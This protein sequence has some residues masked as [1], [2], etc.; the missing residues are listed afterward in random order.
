MAKVWTAPLPA[1]R[2][3]HDSEVIIARAK[4]TSVGRRV[5]DTLPWIDDETE[6]FI[7]Y[8]FATNQI[9]R[10]TQLAVCLWRSRSS[11]RDALRLALSRII[12]TKDRGAS[13]ARDVSHSRP[14]KVASENNYDVVANFRRSAFEITR[15]MSVE[16]LHGSADVQSGDSRNLSNIADGAVDC[17]IT[18]PPY[19]NALDYLRGHRL[20]LI[21]FGFTIQEVR[22]IRASS[23]GAERGLSDPELDEDPYISLASGKE[24]PARTRGYIRR[25]LRDARD[26]SAEIRRVLRPG[27]RVVLVVGDSNL[28]GVRVNNARMY[29]DALE[30]LGFEDIRVSTRGIPAASRYLPPPSGGAGINA[31]MRTEAVIEAKASALAAA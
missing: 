18:S 28:K 2:V 15:R 4:E 5:S 10:L 13:L 16:S 19:L 11:A 3:L 23:I 9:Q 22:G 30:T 14:H 25:Y 29:L 20:S 31:R 17:V 27:G 21:W 12:I 8:W 7:H 6:N 1:E 24:L 26:V